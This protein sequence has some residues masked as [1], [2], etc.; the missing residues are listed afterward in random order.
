MEKGNRAKLL[1][2]PVGPTMVRLTLPM[3]FAV[4]T[5]VAF[6]LADTYFVGQLGKLELA[7]MGFTIPV[8]ML[9]T[10]LSQGLGMGA[11]AVVARAIGEG[12]N[13]KVQRL[14]TDGIVL[15]VLI[16]VAVSMTGLAT[17]DPV[18]RMLGAT[19]EVLPLIR[20]YI[21]IWYVALAVVVIPMVGNGTIRAT[22]D[23]VTPAVIM[24]VAVIFNII[25]DPILIFGWGPVPAMGI[26]GAALATLI[27][28]LI[29]L[30]A[31]MYILIYREKLFTWERPE[32]P[33]L[34]ANWR[35]ILYIGLPAA[36][37][38]MMVPISTGVITGIIAAYGPEAVAAYGV[39]SRIEIFAIVPVMAL[40]AT[41]TPFIAQNWGGGR[42][43]RV[44]TA[45]RYSVM[46][47]L[48]WG[49]TVAVLLYAFAPNIGRVFNDDP[50]V[51]RVLVL[52]LYTVPFSYGLFGML[53][54]A[55]ATLNALNRPLHATALMALRLFVVYIPLAILLETLFSVRG[56]FMAAAASNV[57]AGLAAWYWIFR[58]LGSDGIEML[59][60]A[61]AVPSPAGD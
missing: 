59:P 12:D 15:A 7:A 34:I 14:A 50:G 30:V 39:G 18:F 25:L 36:G 6:N 48:A 40:A 4:V 3:L 8:V 24:F 44:R 60:Q 33:A 19:D 23:M 22:G 58:T 55:G 42:M 9:I 10:S 61:E 54:V 52:F 5:M 49:A 38:N 37:T 57:L 27:S 41:L 28:R 46:F 53:Q 31:S 45:A 2:G 35:K 56:V 47:T 11:S 29:T 1:E 32:L 17:I 20:E 43:D 26:Q 51:I 13:R 16:V 21:S